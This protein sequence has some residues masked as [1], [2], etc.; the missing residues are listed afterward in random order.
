MMINI[1]LSVEP[2]NSLLFYIPI[3]NSKI[4]V[5]FVIKPRNDPWGVITNKQQYDY[6]NKVDNTVQILQNRECQRGTK[7]STNSTMKN[8]FQLFMNFISRIL[9]FDDLMLHELVLSYNR[10]RVA[11][12]ETGEWVTVKDRN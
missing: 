9:T 7:V 2:N 11:A 6:G 4:G 12:E 8:Y 5:I 3:A 10:S 1:D